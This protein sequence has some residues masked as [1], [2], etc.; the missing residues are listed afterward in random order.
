V[1]LIAQGRDADVFEAGPHRV[2]RRYRDPSRSVE[3]EAAVMAY[4]ASHGVRVP[5]VFD[6]DGPDLVLERVDG[7]TMGTA[8][9]R[10]PW[11]MAATARRLADVHRQVHRVPGPAWLP[12]RFGVGGCLVHLDLHPENILLADGEA[13]VI[14]WTNAAT[15]PAGTDI[16]DTWLVMSSARAPG[17]VV[18]RTVAAGAQGAFARLFLRAAGGPSALALVTDVAR[19][20]QADKNMRPRERERIRRLAERRG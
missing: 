20:R 18:K 4:A 9:A 15:A 11:T 6:V 1:R 7:P 17:G 14:D 8:L 3:A 16:A 10:R 12:Q 2:L 5:E 13:V 19:H